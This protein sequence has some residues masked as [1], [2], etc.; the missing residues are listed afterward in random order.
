ML[1]TPT[2]GT[3]SLA[4][5]FQRRAIPKS[6]GQTASLITA[7]NSQAL[8]SAFLAWSRSLI[9]YFESPDEANH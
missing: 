8:S 6:T 4:T 5:R 7:Q 1:L 3:A 9:V 2:S